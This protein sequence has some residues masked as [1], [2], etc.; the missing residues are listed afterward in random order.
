MPFSVI[1]NVEQD[2]DCFPESASLAEQAGSSSTDSNRGSFC[3]HTSFIGMNQIPQSYSRKLSSSTSQIYT[4]DVGLRCS[5]Q[6]NMA[7]LVPSLFDS[8]LIICPNLVPFFSNC[9]ITPNCF[10]YFPLTFQ[11]LMISFEV[12]MIMSLL[13]RHS[14]ETYSSGSTTMK[15]YFITPL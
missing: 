4:W 5:S 10:H 14:M 7:I 6:R 8:Q 1:T 2:L 9:L 13:L 12:I 3:S 11:H 15:L